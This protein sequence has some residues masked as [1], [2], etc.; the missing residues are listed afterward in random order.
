MN[1]I[2]VGPLLAA[3]LVT[4]GCVGMGQSPEGPTTAASIEGTETDAASNGSTSTG[5]VTPSEPAMDD[6]SATVVGIVDTNT[7][8]VEY[9]DGSLERVTLMGVHAP[10]DDESAVNVTHFGYPTEETEWK[11]GRNRAAVAESGHLALRHAQIRLRGES[12]RISTDSAHP[13]ATDAEGN[14]LV[15]ITTADGDDFGRVL[16]WNGFA[17]VTDQNHSRAS[18]YA[19]LQARAQEER[20]GLWEN[21]QAAES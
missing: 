2:L 13:G 15:Y 16:L 19:D 10:S 7:Y 3:L 9:D 17:H 5:T 20:N 4:A 11:Q 6:R 18:E 1:R 12:L 8:G 21:D 14:R